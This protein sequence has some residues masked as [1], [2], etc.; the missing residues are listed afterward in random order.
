MNHVGIGLCSEMKLQIQQT[1][2]V[3]ASSVITVSSN[4]IKAIKPSFSEGSKVTGAD[5]QMMSH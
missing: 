5:S 2:Y 3:I 1:S 4:L